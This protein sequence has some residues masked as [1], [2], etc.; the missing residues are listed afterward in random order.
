MRQYERVSLASGWG[1]N[2]RM[3]AEP[4][5]DSDSKKPRRGIL[6]TETAG[7]L[8]IA[9]LILVLTIVRYWRYIHWS[10]R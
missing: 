10:L 8:V 4:T 1:Y 7:L 3:A 9:F 2:T 5:G 6:A